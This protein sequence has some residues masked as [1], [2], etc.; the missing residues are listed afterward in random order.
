M[1]HLNILFFFLLFSLPLWA[2][3]AAMY[4][5]RSHFAYGQVNLVVDANEKVFGLAGGS[6]YSV[7]KA[8]EQIETYSKENGL[9]GGEIATIAYDQNTNT[10]LIAYT[11][12]LI[13]LLHNGQFTAMT[14]LQ[15][16]SILASK[17]ANK[18]IVKNGL[19]YF[20]MPFGIM[21]V[22]VQKAIVKETYYIGENGTDVNVKDITFSNDSV[23][24]ISDSVIYSVF[25]TSN[26]MDYS[27]WHRTNTLTSSQHYQAIVYWQDNLYVLLDR[28][29]YQRKN[30]S[31][32]NI[33]PSCPINGICPSQNQIFLILSSNGIYY[34][35]EDLTVQS[36]PSSYTPFSI[37][38][39]GTTYWLA[40][41]KDGIVRQ[42]ATETQSFNANGPLVNSPY[43][44]S[45]CGDK[46]IMVPGGYINVTEL[47]YQEGCVMLMD[48]GIWSG[49]SH[50]DILDF[51]KKGRHVN[52]LDA[53]ID[54]S[55]NTH[56]FAGGIG[57]GLLEFRDNKLY[58]WYYGGNSALDYNYE[59]PE[60]STWIGGLAYDSQGN[61]W[62]H[63]LLQ[64][65]AIKVLMANGNWVSLDHPAA[66]SMTRARDL[67]IWNQNE[68]IKIIASCHPQ[69]GLVVLNDQGTIATQSDDQCELVTSF[70]D[71]D[72]NS[73]QLGAIYSLAQDKSGAV[74]IGTDAGIVVIDD[75]SA[76]FTSNACRKIKIPRNDGTGL[77]DYLLGT[78]QINA[79]TV[80]GANRKWIGT[81]TSGVYL[82]SEDGLETINHFTT[83]DSPLI[84]NT[85]LSLAI[86]PSTGRLFVGTSK[87]LMSYQSDA[88]P[89]SDDYS[90]VYAYP[91]PV[92][93]DFEGVITI[94][95]LMDESEVY[96]VDNVGNLVCKTRSNGGLAVWDGRTADGHRAA[97]GVYLVFLNESN[98]NQHAV[99]KILLMH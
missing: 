68:N 51:T 12:G 71:Q 43:R 13:D 81:Q 5:W 42:T 96:I 69:R 90:N 34:L 82:V 92:R 80:D 56:F 85:I 84:D 44:M 65:R 74:W 66:N 63:N 21:V 14:D 36:V 20:C 54:P 99:A 57:G 35:Q 73:V 32:V 86:Q 31:W 49:I 24:A 88:A 22:D 11:N 95:G 94:R 97:S 17:R 26:L 10:L 48:N 50:Q 93:P 6:L 38:L 2:I 58:H 33:L 41:E 18:I 4:Q 77:A 59:P 55:D 8:S 46:M 39:S 30:Q 61:L 98:T 28:Y 89:A 76:L 79:I 27:N 16:K 23:F 47:S 40:T 64:K 53:I 7:D 15:Q 91:N 87:G 70:V 3:D 29:L 62:M 72:G 25:H 9:N 83:D 67:L 78:E 52:I 19:A 37:A 1:K 45:F 60:N 75:P